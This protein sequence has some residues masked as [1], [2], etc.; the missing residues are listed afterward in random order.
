MQNNIHVISKIIKITAKK[1]KKKKREKRGKIALNK[2]K[3]LNLIIIISFK[4][5]IK[6]YY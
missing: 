5:C 4:N 1:K 2:K 6:K 3:R